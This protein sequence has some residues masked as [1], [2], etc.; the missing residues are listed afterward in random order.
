MSIKE[1]VNKHVSKGLPLRN[2][3]RIILFV[4]RQ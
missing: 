2:A 3:Q 4:D 1:L